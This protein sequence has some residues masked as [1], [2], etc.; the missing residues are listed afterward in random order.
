MPD[1]RMVRSVFAR[2][3]AGLCTITP[4]ILSDREAIV[5]RE[6]FF[7]NNVTFI[8]LVHTGIYLNPFL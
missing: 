4:I 6:T 1:V 2:G 3:Y 8:T 7:D 5:T